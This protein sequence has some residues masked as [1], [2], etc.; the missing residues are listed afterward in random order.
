[1]PDVLKGATV[2]ALDM[3]TLLAGTRYRGD[4]EERL[5]QV[6][7]EIEAYPGAIM[8]IDEIH[9]VIGAGATSGGAMDASNLLK[10]A[11][12]SGTI[13]CIGST[14]YKEYR[15][16]FEKDRALVRRFQKIEYTNDAIKAAVDLSARYIHDRK[17]PDKAIDVIDE[18]GAAQ[19]LLPESRRKKTIGVKEIETTISTMARIPPK[20]VSKDDA[21]VL[22]HLEQTLKTTVYG[23]DKAIESLSA[24]IK[25]ARAGLREPEKP[26][27]CY[28]FSGPTGVGKTEVAKQLAAALGVEL[29]RFDMSE[30]MERHTVSRLIGAPPGYVGFDQGGLLTDGVD[31]HP[32]CVLLLD[33]IEKAH[34][35]LFNV[36]LQVMDHGKLTDH[37][38]KQVDFRNVIL[39]MTTNAGAADMA[40]A[41]YGFHRTKREGDDQEAITRMFTP[42]FRNRLDATIT[43]AHLS[44]EI[45]K[46]VVEKFVLQLEAQ[47]GDR[48]VTIELSEEASRWLIANGYDE[49]MGARPMARVIQEHIKKPLADEVLFGHLK[50]GGHVR[51]IVTKDEDGRDKLGFE[52]LEGPI[53]PKPEKLPAVR[54]KQKRRSPRPRAPKRN[55]SV[56]KVPLIKA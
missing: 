21:E 8:F 31:Q 18:S 49:L 20:T 19:M 11:L 30:Y 14:T 32:H 5:K 13:R 41:A 28:L 15:Q 35:D 50:S 48:N 1:V 37:N 52:F 7:K 56:P 45:I 42:E 47:L 3:G 10:P 53:T 22:Q 6:I 24:S 46:Q 29:I 33:E 36:L 27:G 51:V 40:K 54:P 23:Q 4:F 43:F 26:I 9:T 25:L 17:L 34:P 2:F 12:A 38:G 55:G 39:I 44:Q 16:Y